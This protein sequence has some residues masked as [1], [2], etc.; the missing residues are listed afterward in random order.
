[1]PVHTGLEE[2]IKD[3]RDIGNFAILSNSASVN[4]NLKYSWEL[5]DEKFPGRLKRIFSPQHGLMG[6]EQ[7]N[8]IE[9]PDRESGYPGVGVISL[10]AETRKP[11]VR[12]LTDVDEVIIDLQDIGAKYYTYIYT[13]AAVMERAAEVGKKVVVLDR[14]NPIGGIKTYGNVNRLRSFVG[15][16]P[17]PVQ[18]GM[19]IGEL[20]GIFNFEFK[21]NCEMEVVRMKGWKRKFTAL[22]KSTVW[23]PPSPNIPV[24]ETAFV[25]PGGC[26]LEGTGISE[27]RGT[28][29]PFE[30]VGAPF[31]DSKEL[32]RE[33]EGEKLQGVYFREISFKP[34]FDKFRGEICNGIFVHVT[35]R[36]EFNPYLTYLSLI[37]IMF[38]FYGDKFKW[39]SPPYEYEY[40]ELPFDILAGDRKI[41]EMIEQNSPLKA[42]D[43][44]CRE[45]IEPFLEI[46][47][48]Y[49]LY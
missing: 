34:W 19:T 6:T 9:T 15:M 36:E 20:A 47:K 16:Y 24:P 10:Y 41:R 32:I 8:M 48:N 3:N 25:Y 4:G 49:L 2:F 30:S 22:D 12:Y 35:D 44:Y 39:A 40:R 46:R 21:I 18:H 23:V 37:K 5:L 43:E 13:M 29:R 31:I 17:I 1:M 14:P 45:S 27:G 33:L 26:L 28:T 42:I 38:K 11:E 7:A